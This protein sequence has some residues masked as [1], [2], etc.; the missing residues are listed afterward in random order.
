MASIAAAWAVG[1]HW[2]DIR[3]GLASFV[4]D[5]STAPGRFNVMDYQGATVIADYGHNPDAMRALVAA[6]EAMPA[7]RRSVVISGAGD[8]RDEDI[9]EQTA[10]LGAAFD[11]VVL[12][13][14]ACQRGRADGEV[15]RLLRQGLKGASRTCNVKSIKGEFL[16]IDE[17]LKQLQPGD[18]CLVLVDQVEEALAHLNKRIAQ[19]L[20][21]LAEAAA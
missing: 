2:D 13:E 17:A 3:R 19:P 6:I 8:R 16:A 10:I 7:K 18:L 21:E 20:R 12:F 4:N 15:V 9:S 11:H 1:L 14:D 5:A